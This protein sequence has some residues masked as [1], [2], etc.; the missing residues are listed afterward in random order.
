MPEASAILSDDLAE[1]RLGQVNG[2]H[3]DTLSLEPVHHL[4]AGDPCLDRVDI[5]AGYPIDILDL[6]GVV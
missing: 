1:A 3:W 4:A 2:G 6:G 5:G